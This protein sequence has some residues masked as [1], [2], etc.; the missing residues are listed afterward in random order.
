MQRDKTEKLFMRAFYRQTGKAIHDYS[1]IEEGDRVLVGVSGGKDSL[2]LLEVLASRAKDPKQHY[3]VV[4]AH[5]DVEEV[6]YEVDAAYLQTFCERLGVDFVHRTLRVDLERNPKKPACFVCSW[7]RRKVLFELARELHCGKLALGHHRD[8]A[9]ESLVLSML[10]NGT[11]SSMPARLSLFGGKLTLIRPFIYLSNEETA[12]Y[13]E[14][15]QFKQQKKRCPYES[16]TNREA[17]RQLVEQ[18]QYLSPHA[19]SN[20]FAA[21][22]NIQTA[23]LP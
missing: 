15:R 23:Y 7:H 1:L 10:F 12:R 11:I 19:R 13:A 5:V 9:V 8:D 14:F 4:A 20:L 22:R 21:M 17:V 16:S 3:T 6:A 18:M 2:A